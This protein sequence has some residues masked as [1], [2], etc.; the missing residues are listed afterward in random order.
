MA[1]EQILQ[2][3]ETRAS[4]ATANPI[5]RIPAWIIAYALVACATAIAYANALALGSGH[6]GYALDDAY[7]HMAIA[8]NFAFHGVWGVTPYQAVS[9]S[10]SPGWVLVL[11][12]CFKVFGN[13]AWIPLALNVLSGLG[14]AYV[15]DRL[16]K[17]Y[18][19]N[20]W[21]RAGLLTAILFAVPL[22]YF[23]LL[24]MEHTLQILLIAIFFGFARK[25]AA[26]GNMLSRREQVMLLALSALM[27]SVRVEDAVLIPIP[28]LYALYKRD[29]GTL[30][31]LALGPLVALAI[32]A[33]I[34]HG[35]RIPLEPTS[36]MVK[37]VHVGHYTFLGKNV[38]SAG[39]SALAFYAQTFWDDIALYREVLFFTAAVLAMLILM[40]MKPKGRGA[41]IMLLATAA[42]GF[43]I[44]ALNGGFG[45]YWRY[46]GYLLVFSMLAG[47]AVCSDA[48]R[49][50]RVSKTND[51]APAPV[52]FAWFRSNAVLVLSG[53]GLIC[54]AVRAEDAFATNSAMMRD[55][56]WQQMQVAQFVSKYYGGKSV[57]LNDIGAPTYM[58]DFHLT[59]PAGLGS[60]DVARAR[61][62]DTFGAAFMSD[63]IQ[64]N[65]VDLAVVHV[66]LT[67]NG[68][69]VTDLPASRTVHYP[70]APVAVWELPPGSV[71]GGSVM[72]LAGSPSKAA[73]LDAQLREYQKEN[74]LPAG[75]KAIYA[76][77]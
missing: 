70:L 60:L 74:L 26:P 5:N 41:S 53:I 17:P 24:G 9:A 47:V 32:F 22:S 45:W 8:K 68:P 55:V 3:D 15:I 77:G 6:I 64:K 69:Q 72:F 16:L 76:H 39:Q 44:H 29:V 7:I 62:N 28:F 75:V 19:K 1:R 65:G 13:Q 73:L 49:E 71:L 46:E 31:S 57:L 43:T 56:G 27:V 40:A 37:R 54:L 58:A 48:I 59:D 42:C 66:V 33:W 63:Q 20:L 18:A 2:G 25:I 34:A 61:V 30:V 23:T 50:I 67:P 52:D 10:S 36:M 51:G 4:R 14:A 38:P 21:L 35:Q 12:L 11:A